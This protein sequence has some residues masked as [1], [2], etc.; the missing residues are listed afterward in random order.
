MD[1]DERVS[2][3]TFTNPHAPP[4]PPAPPTAPPW[5]RA[6]A[7]YRIN[8][9]MYVERF[10][11]ITSEKRCRHRGYDQCNSPDCVHVDPRAAQEAEVEPRVDHPRDHT[12]H[13]QVRSGVQQ[14]REQRRS[15]SVRVGV[16]A[17]HERE[18]HQT[19]A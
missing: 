5:P 12:G 3:R 1:A 15:V 6:V 4:L 14:D 11:M 16:S 2:Y 19:R 9:M 18:H 8:N 10:M 13:A 17:H 7:A